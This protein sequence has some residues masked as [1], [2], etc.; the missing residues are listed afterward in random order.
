[1]VGQEGEVARRGSPASV[2]KNPSLSESIEVP[3][4]VEERIG[5]VEET[6]G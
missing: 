3:E 5:I 4:E 6:K 1:M 2:F